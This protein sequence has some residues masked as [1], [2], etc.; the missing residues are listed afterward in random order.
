MFAIKFFEL[1]EKYEVDRRI[2]KCEYI[3]Y[4]PSKVRTI[5]TANSETYIN[6]PRKD[7]VIS[8]LNSY[9]D[10][11]FEVIKEAD[12]C[13][14]AIADDVK[15]VIL[16]PIVLFSYY[17]LT[18]SSGTHLEDISHAHVVSLLCKQI[19]SAKDS[20]DLSIGFDRYCGSRRDEM[21]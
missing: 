20:D 11:I 13:K 9:L 18:T 7:S 4:S 16:R 5:H 6:L 21:S 15:L 2:V 8:L 3:R 1:N 17:I 19:T 10:L 14:Y 12:I